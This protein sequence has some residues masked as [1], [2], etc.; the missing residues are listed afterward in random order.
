MTITPC[1]ASFSELLGEAGQKGIAVVP[2]LRGGRRLFYLQARP[3]DHEV[4]TSLSA[5]DPAT[6]S[7]RWPSL[8]HITGR[9]VPFVTVMV[10]PL[11]HCPGCGASLEALAEQH[12]TAF[13]KFAHAHAHLWE[14]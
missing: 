2:R 9:M 14:A 7:H 8:E 5:V 12:A 11:K 6:G 10:L 4:V 13:D 1:C 3:F